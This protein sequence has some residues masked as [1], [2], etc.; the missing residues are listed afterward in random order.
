MEKTDWARN[1]KDT[2]SLSKDIEDTKEN[3]ME[4]LELKTTT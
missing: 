3:Q 2:S 4:I 1:Y